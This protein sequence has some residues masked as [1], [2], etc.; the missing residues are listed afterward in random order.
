[1]HIEGTKK[2]APFELCRVVNQYQ[3]ISL[4]YSNVHGLPM[5]PYP[6]L[7]LKSFHFTP[8]A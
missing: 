7:D 8:L 2:A 3:A 6:T 5:C 1:M 4:I